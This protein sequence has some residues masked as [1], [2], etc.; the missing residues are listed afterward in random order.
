MRPITIYLTLGHHN[1]IMDSM[2][3]TQ[4]YLPLDLHKQAKRFAFES[5]ISLSELIRR[6]LERYL[7]DVPDTLCQDSDLRGYREDPQ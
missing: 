7:K 5:E 1:V 6:S 2:K 3:R 4:I